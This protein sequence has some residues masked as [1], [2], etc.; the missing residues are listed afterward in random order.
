ME[1][2]FRRKIKDEKMMS[3]IINLLNA[4]AD[5]NGKGLPIGFYS[6]QWFSNFYLESL[7]QLI[8]ETLYVKGYVRYVDDINI[9]GNNKRELHKIM[10][11]IEEYLW[12]TLELRVKDNWQV[13]RIMHRDVDFVGFK[14]SYRKTL[15][16]KRQ[17]KLFKRHAKNIE[18]G[19][20]NIYL[21]RVFMTD[22]SWLKHIKSSLI[23][24][25]KKIIYTAKKYISWYDK[26]RLK[27]Y[28]NI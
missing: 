4:G 5:E 20:L 14:F 18:S 9:F 2:L 13:F 12:V 8:K 6:S 10:R 24:K 26:R 21:C 28:G 17:L 19:N 25:Y 1:Q 22:Y 23:K 27:D 15:V 11:I 16:R 7:D 3:L